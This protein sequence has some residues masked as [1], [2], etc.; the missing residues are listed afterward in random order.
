MVKSPARAWPH[1]ATAQAELAAGGGGLDAEGRPCEDGVVGE[2]A[3]TLHARA[4]DQD[5]PCAFSRRRSAVPAVLFAPLPH[6]AMHVVEPEC[7]GQEAP[8]RRV[9]AVSI[10]EASLI[11]PSC[12]VE[13]LA[14]L[15]G[16]VGVPAQRL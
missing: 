8:Y 12:I 7:I 1:R 9:H 13:E 11:A 16:D 2:A 5:V 15:V 3:A 4:G 6:V 10:V 14:P